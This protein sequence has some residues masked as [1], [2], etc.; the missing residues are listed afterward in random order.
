ME[1]L[2]PA[3]I[4]R[5]RF[6]HAMR[7]KNDGPSGRHLVQFLDK[8]GAF[9]LKPF[10]HNAIMDDFMAHIDRRAIFGDGAFDDLDRP[11]DPGAKAA[12]SGQ[13]HRKGRLIGH[14]VMPLAAIRGLVQLVS[15]VPVG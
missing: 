11:F 2:A 4:F 13:Q 10:D 1:K 5:H 8:N 15:G 3:G 6:R 7:R 12:G 14:V 9:G